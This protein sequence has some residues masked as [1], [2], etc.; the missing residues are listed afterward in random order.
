[1]SNVKEPKL[2]LVL[3]ILGFILLVIGIGMIVAGI[4]VSQNI[5]P[6]ESSLDMALIFPGVFIVMGGISCTVIGFE[7]KMAMMSAR[8]A[9]YIQ[10]MTKGDLKAVADTQA[11]IASEA[12]SKT[13]KA[14]KD[15]INDK[16]ADT[17]FCKH[18]GET[19]DQDSKFCKHC[20][21]EL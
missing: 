1:M 7:P 4:I 10:E 9:R 12:I 14:I 5:D 13:T 17:M 18:C 21:K 8:K 11:D 15:G 16:V 3:R 2:Y 6:F 20:G 19:I